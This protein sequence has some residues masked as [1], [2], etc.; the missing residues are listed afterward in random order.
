[1][2]GDLQ[3]S[4]LASVIKGGG[5]VE[6]IPH[7][8]LSL[9]VEDRGRKSRSAWITLSKLHII[10]LKSHVDRHIQYHAYYSTSFMLLVLQLLRF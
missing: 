1:M 5:F 9:F 7:A 10:A 6:D 4:N 3:S 2:W 8:L